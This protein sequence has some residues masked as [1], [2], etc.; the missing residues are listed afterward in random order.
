MGKKLALALLVVFSLL[1]CKHN[2]AIGTWATKGPNAWVVTFNPDKT[3]QVSNGKDKPFASGTYEVDGNQVTTT[4]K[5]G[6]AGKPTLFT[7]N[8]SGTIS[9][10]GK[11]LTVGTGTFT[12]Q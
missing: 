11:T 7:I 10:D 1:D 2:R 6:D 3:F 4:N 8:I 9:D 12:K 5:V